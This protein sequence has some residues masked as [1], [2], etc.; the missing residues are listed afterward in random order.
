MCA[1]TVGPSRRHNPDPAIKIASERQGFD[2]KAPSVDLANRKDPFDERLAECFKPA[3]SVPD[4]GQ[5]HCLDEHI[6]GTTQDSLHA[7]LRAFKQRARYVAGMTRADD[8]I[9]AVAEKRRHPIK[10]RDAD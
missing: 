1:R 10:V 6:T 9:I 4:A 7:R 3:L 5:S 2:V 8:E